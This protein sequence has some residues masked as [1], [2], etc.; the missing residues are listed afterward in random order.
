M[1]KSIKK[2]PKY[3]SKG[4]LNPFHEL[5]PTVPEKEKTKFKLWVLNELINDNLDREI[6]GNMITDECFDIGVANFLDTY[7]YFTKE[8]K[9]YIEKF[10]KRG[11][12]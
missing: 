11:G 6:A 9:D 4:E 10:A 3:T 5:D 12:A 2:E 7:Q 8:Q 1:I